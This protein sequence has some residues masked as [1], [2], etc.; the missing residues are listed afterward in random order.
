M[1]RLAISVV[2]A[3][4][5]IGMLTSCSDYDGYWPGVGNYSPPCQPTDTNVK[6][7]NYYHVL[8]CPDH[9]YLYQ[10]RFWQGR[11]VYMEG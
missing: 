4:L 6:A 9:P 10:I 5:A 1:K 8:V 11:P 7:G 2:L 3:V